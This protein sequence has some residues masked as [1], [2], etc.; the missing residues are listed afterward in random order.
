MLKSLS[1]SLGAGHILRTWFRGGLGS[2]G[3]TVGLNN[4]KDIFQPRWFCDSLWLETKM[5]MPQSLQITL[6][7][8]QLNLF[9]R[10]RLANP[11]AD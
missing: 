6:E 8:D 2:A 3:L 9:Q 11:L 7:K 4:L 10:S 1:S 5:Q